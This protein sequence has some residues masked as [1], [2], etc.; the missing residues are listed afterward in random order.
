MHI[1]DSGGGS[2]KMKFPHHPPPAFQVKMNWFQRQTFQFHRF[3]ELFNCKGRRY[4]VFGSRTNWDLT[5]YLTR[6]RQYSLTSGCICILMGLLS[7]SGILF[8]WCVLGI[9]PLAQ[10]LCQDSALEVL[11]SPVWPQ[12]PHLPGALW[13]GRRQVQLPSEN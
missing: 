5:S 8:S 10:G 7:H 1:A 13:R 4:P 2:L 3:N 9:S 6:S 12:S 11:C